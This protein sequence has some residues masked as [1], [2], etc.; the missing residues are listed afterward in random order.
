MSWVSLM[1][2]RE[3]FCLT[4]VVR[5]NFLTGKNLALF[6]RSKWDLEM[7]VLYRSRG[8]GAPGVSPRNKD[9]N[10]RNSRDQGLERGTNLLIS[11]YKNKIIQKLDFLNELKQ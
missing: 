2:Q 10:E 9:E 8:N 1:Y 6:S 7:P 4:R 3:R 5:N 11:Q